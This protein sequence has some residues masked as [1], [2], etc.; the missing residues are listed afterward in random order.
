[1]ER[2]DAKNTYHTWYEHWHRYHWISPWVKNKT[3]ADLACGEGYGSALLAQSAK[4]VTGIDIDAKTIETAQ[5]K[6]KSNQ[7]L[8]LISADV[9]HTPLSGDSV[10]VVVSFETLEHLTA[11]QQLL[12]E[13]KRIL[14]DNG[15]L[16]LSTPDKDV[17]SGSEHH[18]KYHV[19]E[20][21]TL[22]FKTLVSGQFKHVL[23]F[24]Q[25]FQTSSLIAPLELSTEQ[26]TVNSSFLEQGYEHRKAN[27]RNRPTYLI[28]IAS[29]CE[30]ALAPFMQLG[31]DH[32]NDAENRL[33]KHYAAQVDRLLEVDQTIAKLENQLEIQQK[34]IS[35][36][37][38]R[39]GI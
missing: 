34:V 14:K 3:V 39:L 9:L 37:R 27:N 7:N 33:F 32:F 11:H 26:K 25:Q 10:D 18:N 19:K 28:A 15:I 22:A 30:S 16:V 35:Q 38:A 23:F 31:D 13:F 2:Y 21:D 8:N 12:S 6:Y 20:L 1:M 29:D 5:L 4:Q 17:Y 24:G 36:L